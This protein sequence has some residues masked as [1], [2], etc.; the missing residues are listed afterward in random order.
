[1]TVSPLYLYTRAVSTVGA[2]VVVA[3]AA[4]LIRT[5]APLQ[6]LVFLC[7]V[8][9]AGQFTSR[10]PSVD[11]SI[12][13]SDTFFMAAVLLFG[14]GPGMITVA[15]D[16]LVLSVRRG[17]QW[18][19]VVFN[20]FAPALALGAA[21]QTFF[22]VSGVSPLAAAHS[23]V[24]RLLVPL[25][26]LTLVYFVCNSG[27]TAIAIAL[28]AQRP[29]RQIWRDAFAGLWLTYVASASIALCLVVIAQD[30]GLWALLIILPILA[31]YHLALRASLARVGDAERHLS[32]VDRLHMSTVETLAMAMDAKDTITH[33]HVRR[34]HALATTLAGALHI[35]DAAT[36]KALQT[37]ALLH[38]IGKLAVPEFLLNKPGALTPAEFEHMKRHVDVGANILSVVPFPYPVVPIVRCHHENWDGTGYPRGVAGAAI[39]IGARIL[40]VVDCYDALTSDR[41]YRRRLTD[42]DAVAII[43][44]R[45]GRMYDPD[46]VDAF[47]GLDPTV[48]VA[49]SPEDGEYRLVLDQLRSSAR[50]HREVARGD[51]Q[52]PHVVTELTVSGTPAALMADSTAPTPDRRTLTEVLQLST[53]RV[54][55]IVPEATGAWFLVDPAQGHLL[56]VEPFGPAAHV[57]VGRTI[58]LGDKPTGWVAAYGHDVVNA[59]AALDLGDAARASVPPL[60]CGLSLRIAEGDRLAAVLS[61]YSPAPQ[62][63]TEEHVRDL[64]AAAPQIANAILAS[65]EV[66]RRLQ[67]TPASA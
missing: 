65:R 30:V 50:E 52:P 37:A 51:S 26:A 40:A 34:V 35:T 17:Y 64:H 63:F 67:D 43:V 13:V 41:P 62:R 56:A 14:V 18:D 2:L 24:G 19:R 47:I 33:S 4:E 32:E 21:G 61:L 46:V 54:T 42:D 20:T 10:I 36:V 38:D 6:W 5:P 44:E 57:L 11:A 23:P 39:P 58:P 8:T 45:R 22:L 15:A 9:V 59:D 49:E 31:E 16:G 29:V 1:M 12:S 3:A 55:D 25:L 60:G 7:L 53:R 48:R 66:S 27:L 28:D